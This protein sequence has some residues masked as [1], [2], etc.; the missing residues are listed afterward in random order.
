MEKNGLPMAQ[1][2]NAVQ[3]ERNGHSR[4]LEASF[5]AAGLLLSACTQ[6]A[7]DSNAAVDRPTTTLESETFDDTPDISELTETSLP[8]ITE[9]VEPQDQPQQPDTTIKQTPKTTRAET[10]AAATPPANTPE[11]ETAETLSPEYIE[12]LVARIGSPELAKHTF[13]VTGRFTTPGTETTIVVMDDAVQ[14]LPT[15]YLKKSQ[16]YAERIADTRPTITLDIELGS[17]GQKY[18]LDLKVRPSNLSETTPDK[19][20]IIYTAQALKDL[21]I[22]EEYCATSRNFFGSDFTVIRN[23]PENSESPSQ[24][25]SDNSCADVESFQRVLAVDLSQES[26]AT[27]TNPENNTRNISPEAILLSATELINNSFGLLETAAQ[28]GWSYE[29]YSEIAKQ[30]TLPENRGPAFGDQRAP[31][32]LFP[33]GMYAD[34]QAFFG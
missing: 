19:Q 28:L 31:F 33:Q 20:F 4:L 29:K 12:E 11:T 5:L 6:G 30:Q 15:E 7:G 17:D 23:F 16:A 32:V 21:G 22:N 1:Q 3:P 10:P 13:H 8:T 9:A 27:A 18:P 2:P 14:P 25:P 34:A 24:Q 26:S